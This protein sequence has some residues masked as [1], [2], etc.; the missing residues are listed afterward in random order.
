[1]IKVSKDL[2]CSLVS[3]TSAKYFRLAFQPRSGTSSQKSPK[4]YLW[5]HSQKNK[6]LKFLFHYSLEDLP[7]LED[8]NISLAQLAAELCL[9]KDTCKLLDFNSLAAGLRYIRTS[10]LA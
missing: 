9:G 7:S 6:T 2:D 1:L 8:L 4:T 10:I 3:K 5:H